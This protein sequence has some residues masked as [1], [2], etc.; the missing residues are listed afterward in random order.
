MNFGQLRKTVEN[1]IA[2]G[3]SDETPVMIRQYAGAIDDDTDYGRNI[4]ALGFET[5][6][7]TVTRV[8]VWASRLAPQ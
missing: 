1:G 8:N 6:G 7:Q 2:Q 3:L 5:D 4:D